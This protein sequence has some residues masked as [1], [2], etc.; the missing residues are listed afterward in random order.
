M[1]TPNTIVH[2]ATGREYDV[3][4]LLDRASD[5]IAGTVT[6]MLNER[7]PGTENRTREELEAIVRK[8]HLETIQDFFAGKISAENATAHEWR[9]IAAELD[10]TSQLA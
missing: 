5:A 2:A 1:N 7:M 6:D 4:E 8:I 10:Q 9:R 3:D